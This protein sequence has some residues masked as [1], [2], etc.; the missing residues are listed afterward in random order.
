MKFRSCMTLFTTL[1]LQPFEDA[2][3]KYY[4]GKPDP[5]TLELLYAA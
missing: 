3:R 2:L 4:D 1:Q 5:V